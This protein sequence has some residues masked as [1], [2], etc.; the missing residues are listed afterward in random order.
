MQ[1]VMRKANPSESPV[2]FRHIPCNS[3]FMKYLTKF[4]WLTLAMAALYI[5]S[6][7]DMIPEILTGPF[8]LVD[9]AAAFAVI[10]AILAGARSKATAAGNQGTYVRV[11]PET[12]RVI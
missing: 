4:Q 7:V 11:D 6:P 1:P 12:G 9:D 10:I 8:G 5:V 2:T 3:S